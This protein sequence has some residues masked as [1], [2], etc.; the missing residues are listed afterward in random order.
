MIRKNP[1]AWKYR[2][3]AKAQKP[4]M[5][6]DG[7]TASII[8][9][10]VW[11]KLHTNDP[12]V[13]DALYRLLRFR[14]EGYRFM[15]KFKSGAWN[16]YMSLLKRGTGVLPRGLMARSI[17]RLKELNVDV[18]VEDRAE[19]PTPD[20]QLV[21]GGS[22]VELRPYQVDACNRAMAAKQGVFNAAT[23]LGKTEIM[24][25]MIRR[26]EV[27][28]L[29]IVSS[30]D[31]ARQTISRFQDSLTFPLRGVISK[32]RSLE[33]GLYGIMGDESYETGLITVALFQTLARRLMPVCDR[34]GKAGE[35]DRVVCSDRTGCGGK[36]DFTETDQ[37]YEWFEQFGA[38]H[39]DECHRASAQT[40][41]PV[42]NACPAYYRFGYS[43]TPTKSDLITELRII[44]ATG[45]IFYEFKAKE[46]VEEGWLT[47]PFV[48][49]VELNLPDL[50]EDEDTLY[51]DSYRDGVVQNVKRNRAI[52]EIAK[53]TSDQWKVPTLIL[54]NWVE[55]G[56]E[57][58]RALR[59][60]DIRADFVA[61]GTSTEER[62]NAMEALGNGSKRC[63]IATTIFDEGVN[64][65]EIGALIL[66]GGG[67]AKHKV[68][69]RIGRGL[70]VVEGKDYLA[71]FDFMDNHSEKF[72]WHHS[73]QRVKA[74]K[75]AGFDHEVLTMKELR[76]RM[77]K[78]D[79][80]PS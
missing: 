56:R 13:V 41:W 44:G 46:A 4:I 1:N 33:E 43:A 19:V 32:G 35:I 80:R 61:G 22:L 64:I 25:E 58:K 10:E 57:I 20:M 47:E 76:A 71:V 53:I 48:A 7:A 67:K 55:H 23:G 29:I 16:G 79:I 66:A 39:L 42:V 73:L 69:Q 18:R 78:D 28:S 21:A 59:E 40:W 77:V 75:T 60:I 14:P 24:A 68:I 63:L 3:K 65:P 34:C 31:L 51:I 15:P 49:L 52:A 62:L 54:C 9:N 2:K 17:A 72:L 11:A 36:L 26:L 45:E 50:G 38:I 37:M 30:R 8:H 5:P 6:R 12:G 70:R 27:R 74:M